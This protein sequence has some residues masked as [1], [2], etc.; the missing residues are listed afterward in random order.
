LQKNLGSHLEAERSYRRAIQIFQELFG[1]TDERTA[2]AQQNR[3]LV[4]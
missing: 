3:G 2:V 4:P 1:P